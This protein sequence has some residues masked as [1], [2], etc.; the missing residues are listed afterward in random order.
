MSARPTILLSPDFEGRHFQLDR[1]YAD[2]VAEAGGLPLVAT[3]GAPVEKLLDL[4]EGVVITGGAFDIPPS[5]YG[6]ELRPGCGP[7]KE[8]RTRFEWALLQGALE[9]GLP[10]LGV[11]GGMQLLNVVLGG[12]LV[13]DIPTEVAGALSHEQKTPKD[14]P[15]H[16]IRIEE[17]SVLA[18]AV[19]RAGEARVNS[20]HHQAVARLGRGL[21]VSATAP[22]GVIEAIEA[23]TGFVLGVQWHPERLLDSEPWNLAIYEAL[24]RAASLGREAA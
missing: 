12:T 19:G 24:V 11:C 10:V 4:A 14:E 1:A 23:S 5:A 17:G 2:A 9:R 21:V 13:Q 7:L 8:E 6:D 15:S 3:Y 18:R 22:D 20:T 16:E